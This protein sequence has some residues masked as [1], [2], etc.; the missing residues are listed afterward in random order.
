MEEAEGSIGSGLILLSTRYIWPPI[1]YKS[2]LYLRSSLQ[3][4]KHM[5][6]K[7]TRYLTLWPRVSA[8]MHAIFLLLARHTKSK[9]Y[10]LFVRKICL[11]E[12]HRTR[13]RPVLSIFLNFLTS[14]VVLGCFDMDRSGGE[15]EMWNFRSNLDRLVF[16]TF[17]HW[18]CTRSFLTIPTPFSLTR[19]LILFI[20]W[21]LLRRTLIYLDAYLFI[22]GISRPSQALSYF[23]ALSQLVLRLG[24]FGHVHVG[25]PCWVSP[26]AVLRNAGNFHWVARRPLRV[27]CWSANSTLGFLAVCPARF[28]RWMLC[29]ENTINDNNLII[30][31]NSF[32]HGTSHKVDPLVFIHIY[33][34]VYI[35]IYIYIFL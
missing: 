9:T 6:N 29:N 30:I 18:V 3:P 20:Q 28:R 12:N 27:S 26:P 8:R 17:P 5:C 35:Y 24:L 23:S 13:I 15:G 10:I 1:Y 22:Y 7:K 19:G 4:S 25:R 31:I 21:R 33:I 16:V 2:M 34:Y 14:P 11:L 32:F